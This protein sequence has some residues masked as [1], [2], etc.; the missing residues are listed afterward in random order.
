MYFSDQGTMNNKILLL[1]FIFSRELLF[2]DFLFPQG[3]WNNWI[4][5]QHAGINFNAGLPV[6]ITTVSSIFLSQ[7]STLTVSD[8]SGN[9][10]F[11]GDNSTSYSA[12]IYNRNNAVMPNG[13]IMNGEDHLTPQPYF[14]VQDLMNDSIYYI[15]SVFDRDPPGFIGLV[16]SVLDMRLDGGLGDVVPGQK[17]LPVP[18][19]THASQVL[20]GTRHHNNKDVWIVVRNRNNSYNYLSYLITSSG[21]DTVPIVSQS[22]IMVDSTSQDNIH[23]IKISPDGTKLICLYDTNAEFCN[24]NSLTGIITPLFQIKCILGQNFNAKGAE[25]SIDNKY[26]YITC[27]GEIP[28]NL[29]TNVFQFDATKNRFNDFK[30]SEILIKS[31]VNPSFHQNFSIT[32]RSRL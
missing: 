18:E 14:P 4:F 9:L 31:I 10:L 27:N 23:N 16:Y 25:F 17:S 21:I 2:P 3:E 26:L 11:Y 20:T 7:F 19:G 1:I 30:Q 5:G 24:F 8:S 12:H 15:F 28:G 29:T 22:S 32:A 6:P 13:D